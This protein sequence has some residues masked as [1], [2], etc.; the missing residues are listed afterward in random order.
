MLPILTAS[1]G[2]TFYQ[3]ENFVPHVEISAVH[4]D[5]VPEIRFGAWRPTDTVEQGSAG[6]PDVG[7]VE[8]RYGYQARPD[9]AARLTLDA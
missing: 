8:A 3:P 2:L 6:R 4:E 5:G 9:R 7:P 1:F